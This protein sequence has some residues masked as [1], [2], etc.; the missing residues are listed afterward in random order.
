MKT[1]SLIMS[2]IFWGTSTLLWFRIMPPLEGHDLY[3]QMAFCMAKA[4]FWYL[5]YLDYKQ[6][7]V[8]KKP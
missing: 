4:C 5:V 8:D 2:W 7:K 1:L 3:G 6:S